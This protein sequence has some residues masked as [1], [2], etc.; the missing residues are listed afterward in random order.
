[1][2]KKVLVRRSVNI[3]LTV[4]FAF[5]SS[6][7]LVSSAVVVAPGDGGGG[8]T[9][10]PTPTPPPHVHSFSYDYD[11]SVT[12]ATCTSSGSYR[13]HYSCDCGAVKHYGPYSIS[14]LGHNW[15]S[16]SFS[17]V[18]KYATCTEAGTA[19]YKRTCSRC[20]LDETQDRTEP[21]ATGHDW[22]GPW[23]ANGNDYIPSSADEKG[24]EGFSKF[25]INIDKNS[26]NAV[27]D[28][29]ATDSA[30]KT[31]NEYYIPK[32]DFKFNLDPKKIP[33]NLDIGS[34]ITQ[35]CSDNDGFGSSKSKVVNNSSSTTTVTENIS[36]WEWTLIKDGSSLAYSSSVNKPSGFILNSLG[37]YSVSLRVKD[38][39]LFGD[40]SVNDS[41][42]DILC[43][44]KAQATFLTSIDDDNSSLH[45]DKITISKIK[46][47]TTYEPIN[48]KFTLL[49]GDTFFKD[50]GTITSFTKVDYVAPDS[51][52]V[53]Y[54]STWN[55]FSKDLGVNLLPQEHYKVKLT[56]TSKYAENGLQKQYVEEI[57]GP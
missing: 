13:E 23:I 47:I 45:N 37:K 55:E 2:I 46:A 3:V 51:S 11:C 20:S 1:M 12:N 36:Q 57:V 41:I 40:W 16:W 15:G 5:L 54:I 33:I 22:S 24:W 19:R 35:L 29:E 31:R 39:W 9:T 52:K 27:C 43:G 48:I 8:G 49:K 28:L 17:S 30:Y 21:A 53:G 32:A 56:I 42:V 14:S 34:Y 6:Y 7:N 38:T 25:C 4:F 44:P 26:G 10:L 50:L 18:V